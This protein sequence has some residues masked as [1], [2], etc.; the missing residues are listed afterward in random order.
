MSQKNKPIHVKLIANPGAGDLRTITTRIGQ[1]RQ[2]LSAEG[3][4][5][6]LALAKP[7]VEATPIA[8]KAVEDDY[9]VVIAMGGDGTLGG[10]D[11]WDCRLQDEAGHCRRRDSK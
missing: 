5:V 6:N 9:D 11:Q 10:C 3:L 1:V 4:D 2:Y 8:R 7:K